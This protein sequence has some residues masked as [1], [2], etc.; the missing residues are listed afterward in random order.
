[1]NILIIC[2][3]PSG[4]TLLRRL[5]QLHPEVY[6]IFHE[7]FFL[8]KNKAKA[9]L[10]QT[11]KRLGVD[12][13]IQNWGEKV[14]YYPNVRGIPVYKYCEIWNRFFES[15]SRIVHIIRHPYDVALS[16]MNKFNHIKSIDDPIR[17][18]KKIVLPNT[19]KLLNMKSVIT[20]KYEDLLLNSDETIFNIYKH[21]GLKPNINFR[22]EMKKIENERYQEIDTSRAFAYL[23]SEQKLKVS[24]DKEFKIL[25]KV[26]GPEYKN[27]M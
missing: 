27:G 21:C 12:P 9:P 13:K 16:N 20:V 2:F 18:Y 11:V 26:N 6:K 25:N 19:M 23:K 1:M 10:I 14:P 22:K 4:T 5:L 15:Y 24:F 3:Q 17:L 8:V 7:S